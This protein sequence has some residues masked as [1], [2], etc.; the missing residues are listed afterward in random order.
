MELRD[1]EPVVHVL[2]HGQQAHRVGV[3]D[4]LGMA[5]DAAGGVIAR[6]GEDVGEPSVGQQPSFALES[7]AVE[8]FA[9]EM[10]DHVL[11]GLADRLAQGRRTE[12]RVTAGVVR[13][14]HPIHPGERGEFQAEAPHPRRF[15]RVEHAARRHEFRAD[16][17]VARVLELL[18]EGDHGPKLPDRS[19]P[20]LA[21]RGCHDLQIGVSWE[22]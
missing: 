4:R 8:I 14:R 19:L 7:V 16:D 3:E 11:A 15:A 2:Q 22:P 1:H 13:D 17:E 18:P 6:E 5:G 9:G 10:N 20:V 21:I 12:H